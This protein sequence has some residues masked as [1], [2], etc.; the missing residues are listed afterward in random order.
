ML[1]KALI[2]S[3]GLFAASVSAQADLFKPEDAVK[4]RQSLY[5]VMAAQAGVIGGMAKGEID[6]DA[7]AL[8]QRAINLSNAAGLLGDTYFPETRGVESS[9]LLDKAWDDMEG[10][11]AKGKDFGDALQNLV[12]VSAEEGFDQAQARKAA[13]AMFKTCKGCHDGYRKD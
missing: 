8:H 1:K 12:K 9:N 6:F 11:Q 4:Y 7:A 3:T 13:G 10:M 5:Q 2:L